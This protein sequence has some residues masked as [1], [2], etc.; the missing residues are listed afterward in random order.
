MTTPWI[1]LAKHQDKEDVAG[2][3]FP[4]Y[5]WQ[6]IFACQVGVRSHQ[7]WVKLRWG[8]NAQALFDEALER[9]KIFLESQYSIKR[10]LGAESPDHRTL[11]FRYIN[12][13]GDGLLPAVICKIHA[14]TETEARENA[15]AFYRELKSIFPYDYILEPALSKEEFTQIS[16]MDILDGNQS[17]FD[18]AQIKRFE[19]SILPDRGSS[20]LQGLWQ[21]GPRTH[22]QIWRALAS[23]IHP[24]LLN[25][26]IRS[27]VLYEK[28]CGRLAEC[29]EELSRVTATKSLNPRTLAAIKH[30]N[31][32]YLERRSAPWKKFFYLQIHLAST[33][34]IDENFFQIIGS[35]LTW[36]IDKVSLPGY[37]VISPRLNQTP[38]WREKLRNLDLIFSGSSLPVPRLAEVA[39]ME[40]VL[41][42]MRLP[43][44]PPD[45]GFP[46]VKF[47]ATRT[48]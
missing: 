21:A 30:W 42:A 29:A 40:E 37:R 1:E 48:K 27:T 26:S 17:Q 3:D 22:E 46:D 10:D 44:S 31:E 7:D 5:I 32:M 20:T 18:A 39:D 6:A 12:R 4:A 41:A 15:L 43:Y 38:V 16:G 28:E 25:V 13:P 2:P 45:D 9:Q 34:K 23:S 8:F 47:A 19:A 33:Q 36:N 11:A 14:R 24:L 35:S